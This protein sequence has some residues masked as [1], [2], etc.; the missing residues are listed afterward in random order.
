MRGIP[1]QTA[2]PAARAETRAFLERLNPGG[3]VI[4]FCHFDADGLCAGALFGR[5][6]PRLGFQDVQ[7]VPSGRGASAFSELART[8]PRALEPAALIVTDLGVTGPGV[9]PEVPTLFVDHHQPDGLPAGPV[10]VVSGYAWDPI[11]ASA[12]LAHD[13]LAPLAS[14]EDLGWI[15]AVGTISDLGKR[16]PWDALPGL[17]K[18]Y[19][20]RW[21]KEAAALVN[22]A[23]RS[24]A[25]DIGTAL[26][27]L[28]HAAGPKELATDDARGADRLRASRAEVNAA[29]AVARRTAPR[30]SATGPFALVRL[31][32][33]AQIYPLIAQQWRGRLPGY[34]VIAAN[35]GYLPGKV[36]FAVRTARTDL[37]LSALLQSVDVGGATES[38]G[39]GHDQ[40]SG[41]QLPPEAFKRVLDALGFEADAMG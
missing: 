30:F 33:G 22:A 31:H 27:L 34:A 8:R 21:L 26:E 25:F 37:N 28:M 13:L 17:K 23:R 38:Y 3:R 41:G 11:P 2:L 7:V 32:S 39:H 12:W 20:A 5:T 24:G 6:L 19:T 9:L 15:G 14:T 1:L 40:A 35:T 4:V 29:L 18:R 16:A 10:T 36:A